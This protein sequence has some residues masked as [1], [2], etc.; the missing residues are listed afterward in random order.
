MCQNSEKKIPPPA[1]TSTLIM[2][3]NHEYRMINFIFLIA[4]R[5]FLLILY[6]L[7]LTSI[8]EKS[9]QITLIFSIL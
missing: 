7:L 3:Q 8:N 6:S 5:V 2:M 1:S 9:K 4:I